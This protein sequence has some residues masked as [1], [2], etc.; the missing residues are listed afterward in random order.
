MTCIMRH[1]ILEQAFIDPP[2]VFDVPSD[3]L[4]CTDLDRKQ[5]IEVLRRW[6]YDAQELEIAEDEAGME[7][8]TPEVL[9]QV[10]E[11][12]HDLGERA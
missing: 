1:S 9:T 6:E 4:S 7:N 3:V 12:L 8:S 2:S 11:A 5:K 10:I